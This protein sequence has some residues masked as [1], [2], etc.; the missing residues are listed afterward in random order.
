MPYNLEAEVA[1][2]GSALLDP[3]YL[4]KVGRIVEPEDFYQEA[5]QIIFRTMLK[6]QSEM[7]GLD[8]V[9]LADRLDG[10]GVLDKIGGS[11]YLASLYNQ[12][13]SATNAEHYA[14]IVQR[15][16]IG[17]KLILAGHEITKIGEENA[18]NPKNSLSKAVKRILDIN[19]QKSIES[20][21]VQ[22]ILQEYEGLQGQYAE[23]A[24]NGKTI[25]GDTTGFNT[26]DDM[27]QGFR[28]HHIWMIGGYTSVGKTYFALN[29]VR[30]LLEQNKRI[31]F[32]SLEMSKVDLISRL[33][34][35]LTDM[36]SL[37]ILRGLMT[38]EEKF[39]YDLAKAFLESCD[40]KIY[41]DMHDLDQIKLSMIEEH[42]EKPVGAFFLD[43]VQ[44][45]TRT[46]DEYKDM[47]AAATEFQSLMSD[48]HTPMVMLTQI[49]NEAAKS[50]KAWTSGAKGASNLVQAADYYIEL[51]PGE[52]DMDMYQKNLKDGVPVRVNARVKKNRHGR[53]GMVD[54]RF[55]SYTGVFKE[56]TV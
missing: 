39:A 3:K 16:S 29:L 5:H 48:L 10:D 37:Y 22:R 12:T 52:Q 31:V 17:R 14:R 42:M 43:Y 33:M 46:G 25:L 38:K 53:T 36:P 27:T 28:E 34:A 15:D 2:I 56:D 49:S 26:L 8:L 50:P 24:Q 45:V 54:M 30:W 41:S 7:K 40:L 6:L 35:I 9:T 19:A 13:P 51:W 55:S 4:S 21:G 47:R 20:H 1:A 44:L 32:Y 23:A 18:E 11:G